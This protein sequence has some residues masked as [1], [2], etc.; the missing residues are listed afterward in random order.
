MK[1]RPI[2]IR[3]LPHQHFH[4]PKFKVGDLVGYKDNIMQLA[5]HKRHAIIVKLEWALVDWHAKMADLHRNKES[6][7]ADT[8]YYI[9][10]YTLAWN[11]GEETLTTGP[12][13]ELISET[14]S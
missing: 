7:E 4:E 5:H 14:R 10:Q 8:P 11:N 2:D 3:P 6:Y 12:P 9:V 1:C 13:L